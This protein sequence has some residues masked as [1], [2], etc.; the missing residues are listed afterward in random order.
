MSPEQF[1]FLPVI[2]LTFQNLCKNNL[3]KVLW[4]DIASLAEM[5]PHFLWVCLQAR[6][7]PPLFL[8]V[9]LPDG[10][11]VFFLLYWVMGWSEHRLWGQAHAAFCFGKFNSHCLG[12]I[13]M[14][15]KSLT[16][17]GC[18][19]WK[20]SLKVPNLVLSVATP[21]I[22]SLSSLNQESSEYISRTCWIC[23]CPLFLT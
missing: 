8:C 19:V 1:H 21:L 6:L 10:P 23:L 9:T 22:K 17:P 3:A 18:C 14:G 7:F 12:L 4:F 16:L 13:K 20:L 5:T 11:W 2:E 15:V